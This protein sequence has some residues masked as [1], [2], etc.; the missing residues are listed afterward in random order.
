MTRLDV[1]RRA[2]SLGLVALALAGLVGAGSAV[3]QPLEE[4]VFADRVEIIP[5]DGTVLFFNDHRYRGVLVV[6][7]HD[8]GLAV[9]ERA[10][11][12]RYLEGIAEV[13][14]G[15]EM[16]AL[17][18]QAVAARTYLA[19]TLSAG[20]SSNGSR[21]GY[22]ICAT[23]ACQV[24]SGV[25]LVEGPQGERWRQAVETTADEILV[26]EGRPAQALYSST[27]GGRTRNVEDVFPGG[28]PVPYLRAVA[29]PNEDSPFV[30]WGFTLTG[31]QTG[32]LFRQAELAVGEITS[33]TNRQP[34][35]GAGSWTVRVVSSRAD[36]TTKTWELRTMLNRAASVLPDEL[37]AVRPN[38]RRYPQTI[39]SPNFSI[40]EVPGWIMT[41]SGPP[42]YHPSYQFQGNGW[43]HNVGMSQYGAQAMAEAGAPYPDILAHYYGGLRPEP[44]GGLLPTEV[45]VGLSTQASEV[46]VGAAGTV[47][48]VADGVIIGREVLGDWSFSSS[49]DG[50][51]VT[52]PVGLGLEP[53]V[54]EVHFE[55]RVVSF[56]LNTT[57]LVAVNGRGEAL[58]RPGVLYYGLRAGSSVVTIRLSD[59]SGQRTLTLRV[60]PEYR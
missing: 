30:T 16:E 20:R 9:G 43:G 44:A 18:T 15:W 33:I 35:D 45:T 10:T 31:T 51:L 13:P 17:R 46:A 48:V 28:N 37:P 25:G 57:A 40:T 14:F 5:S 27:S 32:L 49:A 58:R 36:T 11:V 8:D 47:T 23:T 19:W 22:D 2:L 60:P 24:Y 4:Q 7:G 21:Y 53:A 12:D 29:S 39:L 52:P 26:Y 50:V 54:S 34:A 42:L 38:G 6:S 59:G 56:R 41:Y 55:G 3:A 1:A